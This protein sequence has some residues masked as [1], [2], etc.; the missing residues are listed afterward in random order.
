MNID[1]NMDK[2]EESLKQLPLIKKISIGAEGK[3]A[4]T[5]LK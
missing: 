5:K 1:E 4:R 2:L 3:R